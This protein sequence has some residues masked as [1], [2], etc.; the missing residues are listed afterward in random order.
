MSIK[1]QAQLWDHSAHDGSKLLLLLAI[2]DFADDDGYAWPSVDTL[3]QK[4]RMGRRNVQYLVRELVESGELEIA[5]EG[6]G[7]GRTHLYRVLVGQERVQSSAERVKAT[8]PYEDEKGAIQRQERVQSG[9]KRVQSS[10]Q[11]VQSGVIKGAKAIAPEPSVNHHITIKE[12]PLLQPSEVEMAA[13]VVSRYFDTLGRKP[14]SDL[15]VEP[16]V[17]DVKERADV[18]LD[19]WLY[20]FEAAVRADNLK[21]SYVLGVVNNIQRARDSPMED[22]E[23]E[24][25]RREARECYEEAGDKCPMTPEHNLEGS[26]R[27]CQ[28]CQ[29]IKAMIRQSAS[30]AERTP[31]AQSAGTRGSSWSGP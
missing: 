1:V 8:A 23:E 10:A 5:D 15:E 11:R 17:L 24:R 16:L 12:P 7:R 20:A 4:M 9:V 30:R 18:P 2:A 22:G 14:R 21:W 31:D 3:A 13:V 26:H 28:Q 29:R 6:G 25:L 19:D 27:K